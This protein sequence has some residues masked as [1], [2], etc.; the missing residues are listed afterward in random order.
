[1]KV[2]KFFPDGTTDEQIETV[3][4]KLAVALRNLQIQGDISV[5][6]SDQEEDAD[7]IEAN[8]PWLRVATVRMIINQAFDE[9]CAPP[10]TAN[11][12]RTIV[13]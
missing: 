2:T 10:Q 11:K 13:L 7:Y 6:P 5:R 3:L 12:Y 1:M 8:V 9:I 4:T